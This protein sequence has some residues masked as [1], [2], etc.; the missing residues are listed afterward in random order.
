MLFLY[1]L[2]IVKGFH[3][4]SLLIILESPWSD[5]NGKFCLEESLLALYYVKIFVTA[6]IQEAKTLNL[7]VYIIHY[8]DILILLQAFTLAKCF[9]FWG[10]AVAPEKDSIFL[11]NIWDISYILNKLWHRKFKIVYFKLF[12][13]AFKIC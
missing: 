10:V 6:S 7:S 8:I 13:K 11:F 9:K 12:L 1:I 3:L 2:A 5:T 4:V